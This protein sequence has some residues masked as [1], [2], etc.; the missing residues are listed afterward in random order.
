MGGTARFFVPVFDRG[1]FVFMV[2]ILDV[3][4]IR[5]SYLYLDTHLIKSG[6]KY[7]LPLTINMDVIHI[8]PCF[9]IKNICSLN[10]R[11]IRL[12]NIYERKI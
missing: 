11:P 4:I 8:Y 3:H 5:C 9:T 7:L 6:I 2:L 10:F 12:R 1:F